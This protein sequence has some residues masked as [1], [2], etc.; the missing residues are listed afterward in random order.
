M[1]NATQAWP[2]LEAQ[3]AGV[4]MPEAQMADVAMAG[5]SDGKA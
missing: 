4:A 3:K 1:Q 5:G 2:W